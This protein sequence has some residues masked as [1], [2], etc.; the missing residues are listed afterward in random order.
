MTMNDGKQPATIGFFMVKSYI[1][2]Q[3]S[4]N[5]NSKTM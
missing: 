5:Q 3:Y 1:Q 2:A 4:E